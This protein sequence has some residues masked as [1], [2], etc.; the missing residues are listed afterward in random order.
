MDPIV[1]RQLAIALGLGVLVGLQREWAEEHVPG[2]RTFPLITLLGTLTALM[3]PHAGGWP[4]GAG[5]VAV[6]AL[7]IAQGSARL[8]R[9]EDSPG[10]TTAIAALLMYAV[11]ATLILGDTV[12]AVMVAG[13][14]AVLL[15]WKQTLH[16]FV[17]RIGKT[18]ISAVIRLVLIALVVLPILPNQAYG[19][20]GVLNPFKIWLMVVLICGISLGSYVAYRILGAKAGTV[21]GG[22]LGGL[23]SSTATTVSYA[24]RSRNAPDVA[25]LAALVIMIASTVVFGRVA[26]EVALVAPSIVSAVLPPLAVMMGL[27]ALVSAGLYLFRRGEAAEVP[28]GEDPSD[29][30]AAII[31]G[32]LYAVIIFAVAVAKEHFGNRGLYTVA[33]LSGL[34]DM[35][36]I[37]L[38]TAQLVKTGKLP[39]DIGWRMIVLGGLSNLV[40]KGAAVA[41]LGHR[42]LLGRI[43][44][45][46]GIALAGGVLLLALWPSAG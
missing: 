4:L 5:L 13:A 7:L 15:H 3:A 39:V 33:A 9:G 12:I 35:D 41:L 29:L 27:M 19:P 2:I 36:A 30:K 45:V 20:Y 14:A 28:A 16:A 40:F 10:T 22:I 23:I 17:H 8:R 21:L 38:S 11:G 46:F 37:T 43:A 44:V 26:I 32:L 34:T 31:F 6:A 42:R 24:R 18:E 25:S 1:L